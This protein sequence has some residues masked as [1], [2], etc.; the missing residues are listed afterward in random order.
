MKAVL[1]TSTSANPVPCSGF[2]W[3]TKSTSEFSLNEVLIAS[4]TRNRI[5]VPTMNNSVHATDQDTLG[6]L[7]LA[8]RGL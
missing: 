6:P 1:W 7:A 3:T 4:V 2:P 8:H 5:K